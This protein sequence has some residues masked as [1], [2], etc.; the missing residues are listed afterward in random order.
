MDIYEFRVKTDALQNW[1]DIEKV[2][3]IH[4]LTG[5]AAKTVAKIILDANRNAI[6]VRFN[7]KGST[8]GHYLHR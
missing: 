8:Q 6:E 2:V 3:S 5:K 4:P 7:V 1:L